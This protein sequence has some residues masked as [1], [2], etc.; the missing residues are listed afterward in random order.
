MRIILGTILNWFL[1]FHAGV[2]YPQPCSSRQADDML[3]F[4]QTQA[5]ETAGSGSLKTLAQFRS[6]A[7]KKRGSNLFK[8][9]R[10]GRP[11]PIPPCGSKEGGYVFTEEMLELTP[12][13]KIFATGP[14]DSLK[15]CHCFNCVI[16]KRNISMKSRGLYEVKSHLEREQHLKAGQRFRARY[17]TT[18][19]RGSNG[20][21][22][23]GSKL[24]AENDL[25][26]H[27]DV[28]DLEYRRPFLL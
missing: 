13:A 25:F 19:V 11:K 23:Y 27:L 22:S 9:S 26:M 4:S 2:Q 8:W 21:T 5:T 17:H 7:R 14:E 24:E 18:K 10:E 12:L 28:P 3:G 20:R 1:V 6:D 15:N 16:C